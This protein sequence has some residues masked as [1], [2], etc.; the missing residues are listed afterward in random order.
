MN[1]TID[2][3]RAIVAKA[4]VDGHTASILLIADHLAAIRDLLAIQN[5]TT[6]SDA[7]AE[8]N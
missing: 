4:K 2:A 8:A 5:K 7:A 6:G 1:E 3:W